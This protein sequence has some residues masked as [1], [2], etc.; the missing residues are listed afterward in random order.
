MHADEWH[1][2]ECANLI[3]DL[4]EKEQDKVMQ[5]AQKGARLLWGF[6]DGMMNA[7]VC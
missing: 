5:G 4:D 1:S 2:E 6:L 7:S 3:E